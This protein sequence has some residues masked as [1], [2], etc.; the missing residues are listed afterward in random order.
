M[1]LY[2]FQCQRCGKTFDVRASIKER[3]DG[4]FPDCP[5]S[6]SP[7]V[8]QL[9][10]AAPVIR[11]TKTTSSVTCCGSNKRSGCCG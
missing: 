10:A 9:I 8:R 2:S 11:S 7:D 4:L 1:P 3:V 5:N 6:D